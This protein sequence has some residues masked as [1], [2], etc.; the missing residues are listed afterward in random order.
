GLSPAPAGLMLGFFPQPNL[1]IIGAHKSV[2]DGSKSETQQIR[3][4]DFRSAAATT[5]CGTE[6]SKSKQSPSSTRYS[7]LP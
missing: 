7:S 3:R 4:V 6:E 1:R 5:L 2:G